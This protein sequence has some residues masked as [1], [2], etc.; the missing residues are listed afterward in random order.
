MKFGVLQFFSWSRRI[1]LV[2]VYGRAF[3]RIE[4]ME[5][6]GYDCV[7]LAEHHFNTYSVCPSI[8][9]M[10]SHVAARTRTLRIGMAVSLPA[11]YH[12][13]RLA[14]EVAMVDVLSGG[15]VNWGA[16]RGFDREE[17][18][19]FDVPVEESADRFLEGVEIVLGAWRE[20]RLSYRG[21][22]WRCDNVEVLPKPFQ[23]PH[24]PVWL[25]ATSP[26]AIRRAAE[27]GFDILQDP[28]STTAELGTKR[29]SYYEA[30]REHGFPAEG[31]VIP[32]ARLLAVG[33]T[34]QEARDVAR[35]GTTWTIASYATPTARAGRPLPQ[36]VSGMDPVERY[37][38]EVVIRGTPERVAE[39]I[40]ELRESIGLDYLMCAPLSHRSFM[41]FT[42]KVL[43]RLL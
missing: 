21:R 5:K 34:E 18:R 11:F 22:F 23:A 35:A 29:A 8:N 31:R 17:F 1:P 24:P 6:T 3:S 33:D 43:P 30:L 7:W 26:A 32:T 40:T 16:G 10:A 36:P 14:E 41:L 25:A 28:H 13:L 20:E 27:K 42:E 15:R 37:L 39:R 9:V 2:E 4:I 19:A 12:P 38:N